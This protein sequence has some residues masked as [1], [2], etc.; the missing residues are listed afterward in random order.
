MLHAKG[1]SGL[2]HIEE[3]ISGQVVLQNGESI[4]IQGSILRGAN[5]NHSSHDDSSS[6]RLHGE[7]DLTDDF[8]VVNRNLIDYY[9]V[10]SF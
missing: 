5:C 2:L 1:A 6:H 3:G 7:I 10:Y 4:Q 8:V 9:N